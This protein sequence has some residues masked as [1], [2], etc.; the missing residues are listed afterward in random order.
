MQLAGRYQAMLRGVVLQAMDHSS[1]H[2]ARC[3]ADN[4]SR[5]EAIRCKCNGA[6]YNLAEPA[7]LMLH[8]PITPLIHSFTHSFPSFTH[9]PSPAVA[10]CEGA[11][12][13]RQSAQ[14]HGA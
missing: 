14:D 13:A 6:W 12:G 3:C 4:V 11:G 5:Q 1:V 9:P 10:A 8:V 2:A 7:L